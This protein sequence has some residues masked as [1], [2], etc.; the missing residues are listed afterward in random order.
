MTLHRICALIYVTYTIIYL[1]S[2]QLSKPMLY[3]QRSGHNKQVP[4]GLTLPGICAE[5]Y[6]KAADLL[7]VCN[8]IRVKE[9]YN[10][11]PLQL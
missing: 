3:P 10:G 11:N 6:V 7:F 8:V 5:I 1:F 4:N 2:S 9:L